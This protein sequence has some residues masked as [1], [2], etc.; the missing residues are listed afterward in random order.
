MI[1]N[2]IKYVLSL[3]SIDH[4]NFLGDT[5]RL[6][7]QQGYDKNGVRFRKQ[8]NDYFFNYKMVTEIGI[9]EFE[10]KITQEEFDRCYKLCVEKLHKI[11][12]TVR[13]EWN[14]TWDID[15]MYN[16]NELYFALAECELHNPTDLV[17]E[18]MID[19]VKN[20]CIYEVPRSET[21]NYSSRKLISIKYATNKL[22]KIKRKNHGT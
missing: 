10:M 9:D 12:Y 4:I 16:D 2:E 18:K 21:K 5:T 11:R 20:F 13:D 8:N 7:I 6:E 17:P 22:S 14:N 15:F 3:D 1:E 19:F